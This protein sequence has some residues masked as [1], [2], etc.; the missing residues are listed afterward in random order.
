MRVLERRRERAP[1]GVHL[2]QKMQNHAE[3]ELDAFLADWTP[4]GAYD[5]RKEM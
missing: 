5:P 4:A 3:P 1:E 2:V